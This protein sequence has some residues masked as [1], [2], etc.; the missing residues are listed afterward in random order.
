MYTHSSLST[1]P[2]IL[3][4]TGAAIDT[5]A[6]FRDPTSHLYSVPR[7]IVPLKCHGEGTGPRFSDELLPCDTNQLRMDTYHLTTYFFPRSAY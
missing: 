5:S 2:S 1:G 4:A 6:C 3:N 7:K